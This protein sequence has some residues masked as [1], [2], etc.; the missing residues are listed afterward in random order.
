MKAEIWFLFSQ[1]EHA[2]TPELEVYFDGDTWGFLDL[3]SFEIN[4]VN[5]SLF[6]LPFYCSV[7]LD[8]YCFVFAH[9]I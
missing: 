4:G 1:Y 2:G 5:G 6:W 7:L 3:D 8:R 9:I